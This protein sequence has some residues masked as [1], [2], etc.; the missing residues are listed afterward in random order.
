MRRLIEGVRDVIVYPD[1]LHKSRNRGFTFVEFE[2]HGDATMARRRLVGTGLHL[3]G[4]PLAIDWAV[5][6]PELDDDTERKFSKADK[7]AR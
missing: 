3:G 6:E 5:L 1:V 7:L 4:L 2:T